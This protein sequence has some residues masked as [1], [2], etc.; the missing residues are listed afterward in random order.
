MKAVHDAKDSTWPTKEDDFF[1]YS[2]DEH[3]YWTGYF[4][5]RPTLKYMERMG[6]N[7]LQVPYFQ[8]INSLILKNV[9]AD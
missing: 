3:S 5:S 1:P 9:C 2:N 4:T 8:E 7:F 6:N